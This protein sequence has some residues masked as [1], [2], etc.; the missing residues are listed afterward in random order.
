MI[1]TKDLIIVGGGPAGL[2][3]GMTLV[4][5]DPGWRDRM[6]ILEKEHHPRHKLCGGGLTVLALKQLKRLGLKVNVPHVRVDTVQFTYQDL[7]V[8]LPGQPAFIVTRRSEFDHWLADQAKAR[9]IPLLEG[10]TVNAIQ[11]NGEGLLLDTDRGQYRAKILVG[12]DGSRGLV[13]RW[14]GAR[15]TP[16]NV[17]RLLE[18]VTP[19]DDQSEFHNHNYARFDF[20]PVHEGLQG[21][22]WD[23]PVRI[24]GDPHM[25]LG[26][27]DG[28]VA[29]NRDRA[30]LPDIL[31]DQSEQRG[32]EEEAI[33]LEG[34]PIHWFSPG[35]M[36][37]SQRVLLV[38]DAAGAEP[39][40]GEGIGIALAHSELVADEINA[41]FSRSDFSFSGY[42]RRLLF[43]SLG[44]Y[45]LLRWLVASI[46]YRL[47]DS[48]FM[49]RLIWRLA[50][51]LAWLVGS[52]PPIEGVLAEQSTSPVK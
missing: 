18:F 17:A 23:F 16:P 30:K 10:T 27:Y 15:E 7:Q 26:L 45:L 19:T 44:R 12:A 51:G 49:M 9:E 28:R 31:V 5:I 4:Q 36:I 25:N 52:L 35:N 48:K 22:F 20:S 6:I 39:L 46:L 13:R 34:H 41:A 21:Y 40:F 42:R 33:E 14:L 43:S 29:S 8:Y 32:L 37:S 3:L 1:E 11:E 47:S 24:Q 50:A 38:G 2:A